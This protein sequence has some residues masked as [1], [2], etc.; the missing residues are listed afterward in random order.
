[1]KLIGALA[2]AGLGPILTT[3][4][5]MTFLYAPEGWNVVAALTKPE[6]PILMVIQG[7][8]AIAAI[9]GAGSMGRG[10]FQRMRGSVAGGV[11]GAVICAAI[12]GGLLFVALQLAKAAF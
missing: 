11:G 4:V 10:S 9:A 8:L 3:A 1:M 6:Q 2:V 12:A 5:L 7:G